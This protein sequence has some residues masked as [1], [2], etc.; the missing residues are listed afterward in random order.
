MRGLSKYLYA[1]LYT[2]LEI[3]L[4]LNSYHVTLQKPNLF[5]LKS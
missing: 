3:L 2:I 5:V 4:S 1:K